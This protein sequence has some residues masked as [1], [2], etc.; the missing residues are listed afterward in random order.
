MIIICSICNEPFKRIYTP[1][2]E[3]CYLYQHDCKI[4]ESLYQQ[5]R[6]INIEVL[7]KMKKREVKNE[8]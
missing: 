8:N 1:T 3:N 4:Y 2:K 6:I 5:K 7:N